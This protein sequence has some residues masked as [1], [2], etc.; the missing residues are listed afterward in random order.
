MKRTSHTCTPIQYSPF[1]SFYYPP[2]PPKA[3]AGV[4]FSPAIVCLSA[5][6]FIRMIFQKPLQLESPNVTTKCSTMSPEN[7]FIL[8]SKRSKIKVTRHKN[9]AGVGLCTLASTGVFRYSS[10]FSCIFSMLPT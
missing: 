7:S 10:T 8:E 5:C 4:G 1:E 2:L 9:N 6:L 3:V